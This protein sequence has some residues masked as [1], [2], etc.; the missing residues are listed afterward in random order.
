MRMLQLQ[1]RRVLLIQVIIV[2][3]L[4]LIPPLSPPAQDNPALP[5]SDSRLPGRPMPVEAT[6]HTLTTGLLETFAL[7]ATDTQLVPSPTPTQAQAQ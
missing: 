2:R 6:T 5:P 4:Y 3:W 7:T 1:T